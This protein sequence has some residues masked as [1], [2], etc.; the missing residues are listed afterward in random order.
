MNRLLGYL[1]RLL[2]DNLFQGNKTS[3]GEALPTRQELA[4]AFNSITH[5]DQDDIGRY[6]KVLRLWFDTYL[7]ADTR[8][9]NLI[10]ANATEL[11][12]LL[13]GL[14]TGDTEP[15]RANIKRYK[16]LIHYLI[17]LNDYRFHYAKWVEGV[18]SEEVNSEDLEFLEKYFAPRIDWRDRMY[19]SPY[20]SD[21]LCGVDRY[22]WERVFDPGPNIY[23]IV[24]YYRYMDIL[25]ASSVFA[26][27]RPLVPDTKAVCMY[28]LCS[29]HFK[30]D[31]RLASLVKNDALTNSV[32][33]RHSVGFYCCQE[34]AEADK[35]IGKKQVID[36]VFKLHSLKRRSTLCNFED[37]MEAL[38]FKLTYL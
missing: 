21:L 8:D 7:G 12:N 27:V 19:R 1:S 9:R 33:D 29:K 15:T 36:I 2:P 25:K 4:T 26:A 24:K 17:D 31:N 6:T 5:L 23:K 11:S 22:S 35:H 14:V 13:D 3:E 20:G 18:L 38:T 30:I 28:E 10:K 34:H 16:D 37:E 32:L